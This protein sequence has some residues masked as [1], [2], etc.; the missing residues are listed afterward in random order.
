MLTKNNSRTI[1]EALNSIAGVKND[2][3]AIMVGDLGSTDDTVEICESK[4]VEVHDLQGLPRHAARNKMLSFAAPGRHFWMEPWETV[5]AGHGALHNAKIPVASATIMKGKTF[6]PE[7]RLWDGSVKF[8]NPV[9]EQLDCETGPLSSVTILSRGGLA[10]DEIRLALDKWKADEPLSSKPYYYQAFMLLS[11]SRFDEFMKAAD[12]YFFMETASTMSSVMLR[13]YYAM[14]NLLHKKAYKPA[15]QNLNLCMCARPLMAE[16][17][18]LSGDVYYHLLHRF[19]Q[20][21]V[22]YENAIALGAKRLRGDGWPIDVAKYREYP[23]KMIKSCNDILET[24]GYYV[25]RA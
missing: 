8:I 20:A 24:K 13:Y 18:C 1:K 10:D 9:H 14:S 25:T 19:D 23:E 6:T 21:K 2:A 5:V 22:F 7:N 12:R 4:G 17:W 16:F 11:Q 3:V 15:L